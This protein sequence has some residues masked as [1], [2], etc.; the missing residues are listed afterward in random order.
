MLLSPQASG[1]TLQPAPCR[2]QVRRSAKADAAAWAL[3]EQAL[4]SDAR[5]I[6]VSRLRSVP[7]SSEHGTTAASPVPVQMW[8]G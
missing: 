6:E 2:M 3:G 7:A 1:V 5:L 4:Y 8:E